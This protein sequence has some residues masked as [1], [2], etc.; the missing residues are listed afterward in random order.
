ME[1]HIVKIL[2]TFPVTHNVKGFRVERPEGYDF[3]PGQATDVAINK[4]GWSDRK[5][6]FTFTSLPEDTYLEFTIKMYASHR[7]V[8]HEL[9]NLH[10][11]DEL[12]LHEVFGAIRYCGEGLFVAGGAGVTPFIAILRNLYRRHEIGG[13]RLV[14]GNRTRKDI[15]LEDE[16]KHILG[17]NLVSVLSDE[18]AAGYLNGLIT[19]DILG[20]YLKGP[21][22]RVYVCGPE[23]MIHM[24]L[25][26][27]AEL[28]I[29]QDSIVKEDL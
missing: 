13:N 2:D 15:I 24:V 26:S 19:K 5:R 27:L 20:K 3:T 17:E 7:G 9:R 29:G 14:F 8:T 10:K 12:I 11:N 21:G 28:G 23:P 18:H 16:L 25:E 6:S 22:D 1:E 4:P